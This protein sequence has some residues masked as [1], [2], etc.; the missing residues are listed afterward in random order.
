MTKNLILPLGVRA[1]I[2]SK[3]Y[4]GVLSKQLEGIEAERY[5]SILYFIKQNPGNTQ[6]FI[7]D[8]LA[9]DK[10]AM[11]KVMDYLAKLGY[12]SRRSNPKDRR[13]QIVSL[14][15]KGKKRTSEIAMCFDK[16]DEELLGSL[17][18]TERETF[19]N[20]LEVLTQRL[21]GKPL[22]DIFFNFKKTG[23]KAK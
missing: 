6:Q 20:V 13:E 12:I 14:T 1:L 8:H 5:Y 21:S 11:V 18:K 23:K 4:Y 2:F 17:S 10:T 7:C 3:Y 15:A 22:T 16:M 19:E 9:I